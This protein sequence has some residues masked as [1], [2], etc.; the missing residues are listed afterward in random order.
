[1]RFKIFEDVV[2]FHGHSCPGLAI[3]FKVAIAALE[4]L[5]LEPA[6]DEEIVCIVEN[7]SCAVDAIQV[8]T[9]Y[10]FGKRN[11]IFKDY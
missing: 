10:T 9:S 7:D 2:K 4:E 11:L 8:I 3:G 6:Y 5:N 1:M